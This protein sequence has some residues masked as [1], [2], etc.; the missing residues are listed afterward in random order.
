MEEPDVTPPRPTRMAKPFY[1]LA[2]HDAWIQGTVRLE[3]VVEPNGVVGDVRV[4]KS[5]DP[6][7]DEAAIASARQSRFK[8]GSKSRQEVAV[9]VEMEVSF[10]RTR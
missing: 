5:L 8:P 1:P 10:T 7:L 2:P 4:L 9:I 6:D 3:A